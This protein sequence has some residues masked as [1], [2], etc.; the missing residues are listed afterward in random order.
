[1]VLKTIF[2]L[3]QRFFI[4]ILM[5]LNFIIDLLMQNFTDKQKK[6]AKYCEQFKT[7]HDLTH[8]LK[9]IQRSMD[10]IIPMMK[11]MLFVIMIKSYVIENIFN[12]CLII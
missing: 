1:M 2:C 3:E 4:Y 11:V 7:V 6:Y 8:S 10:E 5:K 12:F 9:K